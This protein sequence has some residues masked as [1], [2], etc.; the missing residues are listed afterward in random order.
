MFSFTS[1]THKRMMLGE[2]ERIVG[3]SGAG[4]GLDSPTH[5][6]YSTS[7]ITHG[8]QRT[9]TSPK[10]MPRVMSKVPHKVLDAP[11]LAVSGAAARL[12]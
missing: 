2:R 12:G 9:L 1:P 8:G 7:P 10:K 3:G 6:R 5:D 11:E 4:S